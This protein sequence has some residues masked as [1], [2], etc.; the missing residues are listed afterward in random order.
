ML[1]SRRWVKSRDMRIVGAFCIFVGG[2]IG[3]TLVDQI[4]AA[5]ALGV[6][7]GIRLLIALSWLFVPSKH[8]S[9]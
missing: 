4:G 1:F 7:A 9:R 5:G 2:F 8:Q 6:G 3:R